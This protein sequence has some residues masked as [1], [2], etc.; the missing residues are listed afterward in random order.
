MQFKERRRQ[1][2]AQRAIKGEV[3]MDDKTARRVRF[4]RW[5]RLIVGVTIVAL[6][7]GSTGL[8][9][10]PLM[11]VQEVQVVGATAVSND[12]IRS[13][14]SIDDHSM[15]RVDLDAAEHRVE[16]IPIVK[17]ARLERRWPQTVRIEIAERAPWALWKIGEAQY[18]IDSEG[19][20]L[21]GSAPIDNAPVIHDV[22]GQAR[23]VPGDHVDRDAVTVSQ[24]L[25]Q[26]VPETLA[27]TV[28]ALEYTPQQGLALT[29]NAGYRVVVGDSQNFEYKLAVWKAIEER[30]GRGAMA[31]HVLDLRFG[32]RPSFQ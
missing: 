18:V 19:V 31:G 17:D 28:G 15:L 26:R 12:E 20:V 5:R 8:Y 30:L 24:S 14:A 2:D 9:L 22:T 13:L 6:V 25:L 11:R 1:R 21:P 16:S 3:L 7:V 23:L 29:T 32:D 10:S 27:L 4:I